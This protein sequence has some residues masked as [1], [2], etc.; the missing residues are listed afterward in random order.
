M[1]AKVQEKLESAKFFFKN[2]HLEQY[3]PSVN[4]LPQS[5]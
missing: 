4:A 3:V 5:M 2:M 1:Q